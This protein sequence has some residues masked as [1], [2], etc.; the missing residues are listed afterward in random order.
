MAITA[1]SCSS[2]DKI[3][4]PV[5]MERVSNES[6]I[7][8][9]DEAIKTLNNFLADTKMIAT[10]SGSQREIASIETHLSDSNKDDTKKSIPDAYLVNFKDEEG[11]AILGANTSID[12]SLP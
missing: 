3:E 11:F 8:P 4:Q 6:T 5:N 2:N 10:K 12:P 1:I 9:V 7:I